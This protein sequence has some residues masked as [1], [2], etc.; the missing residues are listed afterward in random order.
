MKKSERN[1]EG[2]VH[3]GVVG[4]A[5]HRMLELERVERAWCVGWRL[6]AGCWSP[7]GVRKPPTGWRRL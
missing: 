6:Q 2:G 5:C 3:P 4:M 1:E 7:G